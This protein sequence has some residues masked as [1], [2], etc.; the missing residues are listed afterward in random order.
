MIIH[1]DNNNN[2]YDDDDDG[3]D[4]YLGL[5]GLSDDDHTWKLS[6][7]SSWR[8]LR[9]VTQKWPTMMRHLKMIQRIMMHRE[10][11]FDDSDRSYVQMFGAKNEIWK[12]NDT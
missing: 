9:H 8:K 4:S 11:N 12:P 7:W 10:L 2:I 3:D 1:E 6:S 5:L